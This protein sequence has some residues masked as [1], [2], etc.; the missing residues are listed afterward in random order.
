MSIEILLS[1][2]IILLGTVGYFIKRILDKSDKIG[3]DVADIKPKVKVLWEMA[4]ASSNSPLVLNPKGL[5]ILNKSG[6]KEIIDND[7][8]RLL[9]ELKEKNPENAYQV[10]ECARKVMQIFKDDPKILS[11]LQEGAYNTGVDV[12]SVLFAGSIYLRDLAL[13]KFNCKLEDVDKNKEQ[14]NP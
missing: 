2:I 7:L 11:K 12:D 8:E 14:N 6:I 1:I 4:F 10:Q 3:E 5:E 13:P 9:N